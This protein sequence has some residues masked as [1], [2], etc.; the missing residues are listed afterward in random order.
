MGDYRWFSVVGVEYDPASGDLLVS[1]GS[2]LYTVDPS[3]GT[4]SRVGSLGVSSV[5]D[6]AYHPTCP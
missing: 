1:N 3:T 4:S 2:T 6:L 5:N